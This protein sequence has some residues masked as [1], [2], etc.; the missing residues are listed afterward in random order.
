MKL[1]LMMGL[2]IPLIVFWAIGLWGMSNPFKPFEVYCPADIHG[3]PLGECY[4][5]YN[6]DGNCALIN[7][8]RIHC[9]KAYLLKVN[10]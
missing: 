6:A 1:L 3:E 5:D 2:S 10:Q 8:N 7:D 4:R 9:G